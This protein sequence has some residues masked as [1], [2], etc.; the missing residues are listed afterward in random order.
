[1][2]ASALLSAALAF[3]VSAQDAKSQIKAEIDRLQHS[4]N[5]KP[6]TDKDYAPVAS[7]AAQ[8]LKESAAA[9]DS[10]KLYLSLEKLL[11]AE[12]F[13]LAAQF[14]VEKADAVKQG[15]PAFEAEW[16]NVSRM[17]SDYDRDVR[18]KDWAA[19]PVALRAL[20]ETGLGR[21]VP[22]LEGGRGFAV[23]TKPTDGLLYLG[24]AQGE[25]A[26]A[27]FAAT[28]PLS[29]SAS[30]FP[31]RSYLPEL[32][33][34]QRETNEAF[35]PPRSIKLH[36]RFIALNS[37]LKLAQELDAQKSYAGALYQFLE[38]TRHFFMLDAAPVDAANQAGLRAGIA[39]ARKKFSS[40]K[41]D[42][43]LVLLFLERA[44]SQINHADGSAPS[45]D[46]WRAAK[47]ILDRVLPAYRDAQKSPLPVEQAS[48]KTVDLTLVR[49]PYT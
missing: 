11:Q 7:I 35:Q 22:L 33:K 46:E 34:L 14:P 27:K 39:S 32:Q 25:A 8:S 43:S 2:L 26:F 10:G 20:A 42:D 45:A 23:S 37:T 3:S 19:S 13:A 49:W 47:V 41:Q 31:I 5:E 29:V 4:L 21:S 1:M 18:Q 38:A 44:D 6:I 9:L 30:P 17:L 12:D 24:Q 40:S 16:K 28:L 48:G 36:E 15:L